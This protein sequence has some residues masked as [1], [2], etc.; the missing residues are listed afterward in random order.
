MTAQD[1]ERMG[2]SAGAALARLVEMPRWPEDTPVEDHGSLI[3]EWIDAL[4]DQCRIELVR[5]Y[6]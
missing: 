4:V 2:R 1:A 5:N 6:R 3:N